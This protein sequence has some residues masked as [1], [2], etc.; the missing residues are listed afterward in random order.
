MQFES[1]VT[2][3]SDVD[4][5]LFDLAFT[6]IWIILLWKRG[7]I[8]PLLFGF[9]GI[10]INFTIDFGI[11]YSYLGTRTVEGLPSWISPVLFFIYFS[12]TYG[13]VQYSYVQVMFSTQ[14]GRPKNEKRERLHW[15]MFL[16][17]GWLLVGFISVLV[18]IDD[19]KVTVTR[20]M[21][22]QRIFEAYAVAGEYALLVILAHFKRFDLDW[23]KIGYIFL[24]GVFVHFSME[25]TLFLSGIRQSG[26]FDLVFNSLFEFNMGAPLLYLMLVVIGPVNEKLAAK[27]ETS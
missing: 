27:Q 23:R 21:T 9:L 10:V 18:P 13:M 15:S 8:K 25:F 4:F 11:W 22:N 1:I 7:Y 12:I 6:I 24:V 14:P 5:M 2:R 26:L 17:F 16:F 20:I 19:T 3:T